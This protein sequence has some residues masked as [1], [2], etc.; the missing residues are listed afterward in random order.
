MKSDISLFILKENV[1]LFLFFFF[2]LILFLKI[3]NMY[4]KNF[5]IL[6]ILKL[7]H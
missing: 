5:A 6:T 2:F 7:I 3:V 4:N 1:S